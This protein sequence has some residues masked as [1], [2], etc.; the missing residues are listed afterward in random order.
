VIGPVTATSQ[1]VEAATSVSSS[2]V[3]DKSNDGLVGLAFSS[4]NTV[5]PNAATTFF[6]TVSS[7]LSSALFAADLKKGAPGSY[8]FGVS[9]C[10]EN[11]GI[12]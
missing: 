4:I 12:S 5:K 8:D 1:A 9:A 6:D 11:P 2:F 3:T 7:S 10:L